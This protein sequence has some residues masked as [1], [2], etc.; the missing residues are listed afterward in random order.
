MQIREGMEQRYER[1]VA[2]NSRDA[3]ERAGVKLVQV[4][5]GMMEKVMEHGFTVAQAAE[6]TSDAADLA[7][8]ASG[9]LHVAGCAALQ[10]YWAHGDELKAW[11]DQKYA[12][13]QAGVDAW[14]QQ[15]GARQMDELKSRQARDQDG[16][17]TGM[18]MWP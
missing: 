13:E 5:G 6:I 15:E 17:I 12:Q 2:V 10:R 9:S 18:Q 8:G 16:P 11:Q 14:Y 1:F 4:W 3:Y 7:V